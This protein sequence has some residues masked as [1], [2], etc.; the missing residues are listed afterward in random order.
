MVDEFTRYSNAAIIK[1]KS[2]V[3]QAFLRYWIS[4][5]GPPK[6]IFT[7]NGGEFIGDTIY[8]LCAAF[9][10]KQDSTP[11]YFPWSNG[12][13][14]RQNQVLT[15]MVVKVK[16]EQRCTW[17]TALAWSISAKNQLI[18]DKGFSPAKLVF[19]Q[20]GT[21]PSVSNNSLPALEDVPESSAADIHIAALHSAR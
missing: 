9:N 13:C 3:P 16:D 21:Y 4:L 8:D 12:L 10:I 17:E 7:D 1:S 19:G 18:N 14:E 5:F 20:N 6:K 11:G 2:V 15:E